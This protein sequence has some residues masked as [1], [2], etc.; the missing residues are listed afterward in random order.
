[1]ALCW[2]VLW[3]HFGLEPNKNDQPKSD[4]EHQPVCRKCKKSVP[5][6]GGNTSNSMSH[7]KEHHSDLYVEALTEQKQQSK[8]SSLKSGE[9]EV[10]SSTEG[11]SGATA[12]IKDI[13]LKNRKYGKRLVSK[14]V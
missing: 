3:T 14:Q 9:T 7:L 8:G 6:K 4:K 11:S 1:M 10:A 13:L 12:N 2:S 5:A